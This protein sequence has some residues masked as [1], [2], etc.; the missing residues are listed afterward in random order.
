MFLPVDESE[1][2]IIGRNFM[3]KINGNIGNSALG[4]SI[5]EEVDKMVW[6]IRHLGDILTL[7]GASWCL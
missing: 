1:P 4:S 5:D 3:V 7:F 6:G 2:M